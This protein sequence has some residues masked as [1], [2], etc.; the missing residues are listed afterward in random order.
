MLS[1]TERQVAVGLLILHFFL[2]IF[3]LQWSIE[4]LILPGAKV[5]IAQK[6]NGMPTRLMGGASRD[7]ICLHPHQRDL[8][9]AT[10]AK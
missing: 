3:L 9:L 4:K 5:R 10:D 7:D 1:A 6:T 8:C 2:G